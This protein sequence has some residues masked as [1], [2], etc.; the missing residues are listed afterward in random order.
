MVEERDGALIITCAC[1]ESACATWMEIT[2]EG[3]LA[4]EDKDGERL[5]ILL[6]EWLEE[7]M[8]AAVAIRSLTYCT[9]V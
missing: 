1:H 7:A 4:V 2:P 8:R 3:V 9:G 6:P 5:S